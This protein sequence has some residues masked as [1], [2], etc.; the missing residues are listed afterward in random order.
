MVKARSIAIVHDWFEEYSGAEKVTKSLLDLLPGAKLFS[1][2]NHMDD[3]TKKYFGDKQIK[4]TFIQRLPFSK[5]HFRFYLP[6]FPLAVEQLNVSNYDLVI[7]SSHNVSKG[8]LVTHNQILV[9]YCHSPIRYAWDLYHLYTQQAITSKIKRVFAKTFLHYIRMWDYMAAQR[10]DFFIANSEYV[11]YRIKKNYNRDSIVIHPP[12]DTHKY[13]ISEEVEDYYV[14]VSRLVPYKQID[15]I[16]QAFV[17]NG[18]KL[19]VIGQGGELKKLQGIA[20][21]CENIV[22]TGFIEEK[23]LIGKLQRAKAFVFA[24]EED[25]GI[26]PVEA[27][28]AGVPVIAYAR[29]GILETVIH[30]KTGVLFDECTAESIVEAIG[31]FERNEKLFDRKFIKQHAEKFSVQRFQTEMSAFLKRTDI[32]RMHEQNMA[33]LQAN[34]QR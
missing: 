15:K 13:S 23:Q 21:N 32:N 3:E 25:F 28:A 2:V 1:L 24:A 19:L 27:Q 4:T 20:K 16:V 18:K 33:K 9:C 10:V 29:G 17:E 34:V 12:V 14:T 8:A 26:A 22:F 5:R 31:H 11:R 6:L 30:G 7:A